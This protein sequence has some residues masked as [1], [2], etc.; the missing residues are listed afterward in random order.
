MKPHLMIL[1]AARDVIA[2]GFWTTGTYARNERGLRVGH[3]SKQACSFCAYGALQGAA[4]DLGASEDSLIKA[5]RAL[6][7]SA[8]H[9]N[10][11]WT[12]DK[13]ASNRRVVA[14]FDHALAAEWDKETT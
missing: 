14:L 11:A 2:A 12:N 3:D 1:L 13:A 8:P 10:V 5:G 4:H 7:D 6:M 9:C